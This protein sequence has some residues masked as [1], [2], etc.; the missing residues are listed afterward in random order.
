M[1]LRIADVKGWTVESEWL[2]EVPKEQWGV[3]RRL[4]HNWTRFRTGSHPKSAPKPSRKARQNMDSP[5][6][7]HSESGLCS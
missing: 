1:V 7:S 4:E 3:V 2:A 5:D 6:M